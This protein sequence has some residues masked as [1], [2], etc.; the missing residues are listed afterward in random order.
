MKT[1]LI[2]EITSS[3]PASEPAAPP[4]PSVESPS[5]GLRSSSSGEWNA[6]GSSVASPTQDEWSDQADTDTEGDSAYLSEPDT[7]RRR[8]RPGPSGGEQSGRHSRLSLDDLEKELNRFHFVVLRGASRYTE[9]TLNKEQRTFAQ[10][11]RKSLRQR[12]KRILQMAE[13]REL[14]PDD[15]QT[16][17]RLARL[18]EQVPTLRKNLDPSPTVLRNR[19]T[20]LERQK[21]YRLRKKVAPHGIIVAHR[22]RG[23]SKKVAKQPTVEVDKNKATEV[24]E[25][26]RRP[27]AK[28]LEDLHGD[29]SRSLPK[30]WPTN[31]GKSHR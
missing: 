26:S 22:K 23:G 11:A 2:S 5:S 21:R 18:I 3:M 1:R 25:S 30:A 31:G 15:V 6:D 8:R 4:C 28:H 24:A 12:E 10:Y 9:G 13:E 29:I 16:L 17:G 20:G 14:L 27:R 7:R 19:E